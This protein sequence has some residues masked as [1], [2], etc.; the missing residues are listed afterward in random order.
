MLTRCEH[1]LRQYEGG[2]TYFSDTGFTKLF[3][4]MQVDG[5]FG[6]YVERKG[7]CWCAHKKVQKIFQKSQKKSSSQKS[8]WHKKIKNFKETYRNKLP[9]IE[10]LRPWF[11]TSRV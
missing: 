7:G 10:S 2:F 9:G 3:N 8:L 5:F 4:G 11:P 1:K 6:A